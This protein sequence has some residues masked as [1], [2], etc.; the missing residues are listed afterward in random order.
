MTKIHLTYDQKIEI[1]K[2]VQSGDEEMAKHLIK[3][4][5]IVNDRE[6]KEYIIKLRSIP[7]NKENNLNQ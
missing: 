5:A 3:N 1:L 4:Y 2:L 7:E 6:A